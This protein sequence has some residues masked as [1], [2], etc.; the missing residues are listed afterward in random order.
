MLVV[1]H[2][3][4]SQSER[5]VWLCEEL[6]LPYE[7]KRYDRVQGKG[8]APPEYKALWPFGTAPVIQD[9]VVVLG[10]SGAI[11][12]YICG[13]YGRGRLTVAPGAAN[14]APYLF[15][16]HFANGSFMPSSMMALTARLP[17]AEDNPRNRVQLERYDRAFAMAEKRLGEVPYF[18]GSDFTAADIMM[19]FPLTTMRMFGARDIAGFPNLLAYLQRIG[20]CPAYQRAMKKGDPGLSPKLT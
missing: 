10:E 11:V 19:V 9:G 17:G 18:A 16:F 1:H 13:R 20:A 5:I 15:W 2:L 8:V 12:E 4:V 6:E 3:G 14:F 7:L